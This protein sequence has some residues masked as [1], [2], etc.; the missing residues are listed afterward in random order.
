MWKKL[1]QSFKER[2]QGKSSQGIYHRSKT[3]QGS[4]V[5]WQQNQNPTKFYSDER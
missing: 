3:P 5:G 2:W 4:K 1:M